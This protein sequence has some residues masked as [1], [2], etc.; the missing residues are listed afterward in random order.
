MIIAGVRMQ[1]MAREWAAEKKVK[2]ALLKGLE[3]VRRKRKER[4]AAK[5]RDGQDVR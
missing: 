5:S 2:A 1:R 4:E 3:N